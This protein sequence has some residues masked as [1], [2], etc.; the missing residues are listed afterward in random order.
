MARKAGRGG[1][2]IKKRFLAGAILD[3]AGIKFN[4]K[5]YVKKDGKDK[6]SR[7]YKGLMRKNI[8]ELE[9]LRR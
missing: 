8:K 7:E 2:F 9:R 6:Y 4:V 3:K 5:E 1:R